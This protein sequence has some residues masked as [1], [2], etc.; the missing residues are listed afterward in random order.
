[1]WQDVSCVMCEEV[2]WVSLVEVV[3][4]LKYFEERDGS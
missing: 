3:D 1:M 2:S 4:V